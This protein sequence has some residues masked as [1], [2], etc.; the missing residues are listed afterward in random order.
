MALVLIR[1]KDGYVFWGPSSKVDNE[2]F[3]L[4]KKE[5][6]KDGE[7]PLRKEPSPARSAVKKEE[8][9]ETPKRGRPKKS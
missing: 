9:K 5:E 7:T 8:V 3:F 4:V 6:K 2:E 1:R